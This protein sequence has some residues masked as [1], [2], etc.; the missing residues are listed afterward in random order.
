VINLNFIIEAFIL[1]VTSVVLLRFTGK[2]SVAKMTNLETVIILAIGTT[3]GHA[4]KEHKFWQV[5]L[6]L[7]FFGVFL[8]ILQKIQMKSSNMERYMIGEA[9][10]VINDGKIIRSNI[11][12]LR[13]TEG[14]LEM[15]LRQ[16]GISYVS[17]V[18]I[19]T[20]ESDGEFG[21]ELMPH[22]KPIT[23]EQLLQILGKQGTEG[24]T[25]VKG[26]N[27]FDQVVKNNK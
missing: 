4:I 2:K 16:K 5:I 6:I 10:L 23:Q 8:I 19:G 7:I 17:D 3:M 11:R 14:Q 1:L 26:E 24:G 25:Q 18:K 12:K 13:M 21:F 20:I 9:T 27:I 15:R 22:A